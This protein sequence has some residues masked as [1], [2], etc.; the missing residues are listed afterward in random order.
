MPDVHKTNMATEETIK[1]FG[2]NSNEKYCS[3]K[4]YYRRYGGKNASV[5]V[6]SINCSGCHGEGQCGAKKTVALKSDRLLFQFKEAEIFAWHLGEKLKR[7]VSLEEAM[8]EWTR[9]QIPGDK[10]SSY[11]AKFAAY[12]DVAGID[13]PLF[14]FLA[15][16]ISRAA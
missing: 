11:A 15:S 4:E 10:N 5:L 2:E 6:D 7:Y 13:D 12:H 1:I 16:R 3:F 14:I 8:A 9:E